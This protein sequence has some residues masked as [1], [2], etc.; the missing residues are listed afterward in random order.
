MFSIEKFQSNET[1]KFS[2]SLSQRQQNQ[3]S[4]WLLLYN[5]REVIKLTFVSSIYNCIEPWEIPITI[6]FIFNHHSIC[7][8]CY[9]EWFFTSTKCKQRFTRLNCQLVRLASLMKFNRKTFKLNSYVLKFLWMKNPLA[10]TLFMIW[11]RE[12]RRCNF[13]TSAIGNINNST[14]FY[15]TGRKK[16]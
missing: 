7:N 13:V 1:S 4:F 9:R 15:I 10:F 16:L 11:K 14:T 2:W 8:G 6:C 5:N 12:E 3:W